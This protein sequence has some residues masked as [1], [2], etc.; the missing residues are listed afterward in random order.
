MNAHLCSAADV[1]SRDAAVGFI[2]RFDDFT[3]FVIFLDVLPV[4]G[5]LPC[6]PVR[7]P[8]FDDSETEPYRMSFLSH[9]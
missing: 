4:A 3:D 6:E 2:L 1:Y 5:W 9:G 7:M 8:I